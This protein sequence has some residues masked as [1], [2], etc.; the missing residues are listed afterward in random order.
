MNEI[1]NRSDEIPDKYSKFNP[2]FASPPIV[3][4][5]GGFSLAHPIKSGNVSLEE[6]E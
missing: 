2:K 6:E 3:K 1:K 4:Q 5:S